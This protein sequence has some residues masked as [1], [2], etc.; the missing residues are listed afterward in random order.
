MVLA[1]LIDR[2]AAFA[3][4]EDSP[5]IPGNIQLFNIFSEEISAVIKARPDLPPEDIVSLEVS[6]INLVIRVTWSRWFSSSP[7]LR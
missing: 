4:R 6:L 3:T 5:G 1:A 7:K 2:L